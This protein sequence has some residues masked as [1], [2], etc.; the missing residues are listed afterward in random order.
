MSQQLG[1]PSPE[2][3]PIVRSVYR[4]GTA[5][6]P[7]D[8]RPE[9]LGGNERLVPIAPWST[10]RLRINISQAGVLT[11]F[12]AD[13]KRNEIGGRVA[14]VGILTLTAN[15]NNN[16]TVTIG[17]QVYTA[18][19]VL[20]DV[21]GNFL[22]GVAATNTIDNLIAAIN[23]EAAVGGVAGPGTLYAASTVRNV[24]VSAVAGAGDTMDVTATYGGTSGDAITTVESTAAARMSWGGATLGSG[25]DNTD[26]AGDDVAIV[27]DAELI[28]NISATEHV[29]EAWLGVR[30]GALTAAADVAV[31][32][33]SGASY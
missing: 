13:S 17:G 14:S 25:V 21:N 11:L 3:N 33:A 27:A 26:I 5:T 12:F 9:I 22:I 1:I 16:D 7:I 30:I 24:D 15:L 6:I 29:G 32:E 8:P 31:F 4:T 20:T 23:T 10:V 19:T 2:G 28:T 18:Q